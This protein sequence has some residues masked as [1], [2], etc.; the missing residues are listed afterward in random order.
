MV[1]GSAVLL[2]LVASLQ[3]SWQWSLS[4]GPLPHSSGR[5]S[6]CSGVGG[7]SCLRRSSDAMMFEAYDLAPVVGCLQ[8][9]DM[10]A[11]Q[12]CLDNFS[13][14]LQITDGGEVIFSDKAIAGFI[15]GSVG[16]VGT[17]IAT[18]FKR[19][20]V[21]DRLKCTYCAGTGQITCGRCFGSGTVSMNGQSETCPTCEGTG[22]VVCINCQ[23]T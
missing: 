9:P 1:S 4:S 2:L 3:P 18:L 23:A 13:P 5:L 14:W 19:D 17:V 11:V 15:G 8:S 16:V 22:T 21:K 20:E 10:D 6:H 7:G 12:V